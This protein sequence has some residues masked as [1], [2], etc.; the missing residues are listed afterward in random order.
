MVAASSRSVNWCGAIAFSASSATAPRV[1]ITG[2]SSSSIC[3]ARKFEQLEIS[4]RVGLSFA[5]L[6]LRGLQR[7]VLVMK[8]S[9][10]R[11]PIEASSCS[12]FAPELSPSNGRRVRSAPF[13]PG[14][15][16]IISSRGWI[17]PLRGPITAFRSCI[18]SHRWQAVAAATSS[19]NLSSLFIRRDYRRSVKSGKVEIRFPH[20]YNQQVATI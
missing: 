11:S 6:A 1:T 12:K 7:T 2:G 4:R 15:S 5:P 13:R 3:R 8:I 16:A 14:A 20:R 17:V 9:S 18:R 10:R 19:S